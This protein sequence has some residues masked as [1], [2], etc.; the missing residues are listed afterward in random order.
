MG[1]L[2]YGRVV[3]CLVSTVLLCAAVESCVRRSGRSCEPCGTVRQ[4]RMAA[5]TFV[6][7]CERVDVL[8]AEW[9][10]KPVRA[11]AKKSRLH[12]LHR[13]RLSL[14]LRDEYGETRLGVRVLFVAC[15]WRFKCRADCMD[16][17]CRSRIGGLV[18]YLPTAGSRRS[19]HNFST[20][21]ADH[22]TSGRHLPFTLPKV[23]WIC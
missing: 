3:P 11:T 1:L 4:C 15:G 18:V 14:S 21:S 12:T 22:T 20:S 17:S 19:R 8:K 6:Y 7:V 13:T 2:C 5:E 10:G 23:S 16:E 9:R